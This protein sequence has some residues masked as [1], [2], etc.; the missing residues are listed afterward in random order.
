MASGH[1][2]EDIDSR[3]EYAVVVGDKEAHLG[4]RVVTLI[5]NPTA[6]DSR[7]TRQDI[8]R[9]LSDAGFQV[10]YQSSKGD[11]KKAVDAATDAIVVAGGDGTVAKVFTRV[12][13]RDI[14]VG[15]LALGTANNV[16]RAL[17]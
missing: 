15:V 9:I 8:E 4:S 17:G 1:M 7:P 11:W 12:A 6:G 13:G 16:A 5:H 3:A 10:R 2:S 14:P